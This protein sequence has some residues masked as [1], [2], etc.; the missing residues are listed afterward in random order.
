MK[1]IIILRAAVLAVAIATP[2]LAAMDDGKKSGHMQDKAD[3][4]FKRVDTNGDG[5]ITKTEHDAFANKMFTDADTNKDGSI[6]MEEMRAHKKKE[7]E[8]HK[9]MHKDMHEDDNDANTG[10]A[11]GSENGTT[12]SSM[13][14]KGTA[15]ES[16]TGSPKQ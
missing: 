15:G 16:G 2:A 6:S 9:A 8:E 13:S 12:G 3:Y 11:G 4:M 14:G 5:K 1:K 7:W 10:T